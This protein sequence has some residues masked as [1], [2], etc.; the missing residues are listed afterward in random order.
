[1]NILS[2]NLYIVPNFVEVLERIEQA[3]DLEIQEIIDS[4]ICRYNEYYP[5]WEVM[6]LSLHKD[7]NKRKDDIARIIDMLQNRL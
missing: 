1:M 2:K 7:K 3:N 4:I 6:F 5:E